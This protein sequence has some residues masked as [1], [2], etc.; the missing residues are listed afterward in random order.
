MPGNGGKKLGAFFERL[1]TNMEDNCRSGARGSPRSIDK[2]D[3]LE[4]E[5]GGAPRSSDRA[6]CLEVEDN[7]KR[8]GDAGT[9]SDLLPKLCRGI[10]GGSTTPGEEGGK[11]AGRRAPGDGRQ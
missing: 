11:I 5:E 8:G 7:W 2:A 4:V 9:L 6:D 1:E 10:S 3:C